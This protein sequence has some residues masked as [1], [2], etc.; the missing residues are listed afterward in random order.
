MTET[1]PPHRGSYLSPAFETASV[2][3]VM[4]PGVMSCP[5]SASL[6]TVAQTMATHHVHAVVIG[7]VAAEASQ[8]DRL[9]WGLISD[10]D[11]VRASQTGIEGQT[12]GDVSRT[13]AV[14]VDPS[15]PLPAAAKLMLEHATSHLLVV[16]GGAPIGVISS[17]DI[18][19]ALAWGRA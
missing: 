15:T 9:V 8:G 2:G 7:G 1:A 6:L 3:D 18:A 17:L 13:E 11:L 19:G 14:N 16:S 10:M 4:H 12:A 5:S